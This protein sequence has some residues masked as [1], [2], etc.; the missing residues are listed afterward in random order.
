V[1]F[2]AGVWLDGSSKEVQEVFAVTAGPTLA[3]DLTGSDVECGEQV[4]GAVPD[5]VVGALLGGVELDWQ[6]WLGGPTAVSVGSFS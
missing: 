6:Q 5:V 3:E 4:R 2:L 1:D